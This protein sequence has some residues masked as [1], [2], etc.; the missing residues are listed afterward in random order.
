MRPLVLALLFTLAACWGR[1]AYIVEG[2]VVEVKDDGVV[3]IDHQEIPGFMAAM[4]MP[5][6][7]SDPAA[8]ASLV[9]G[10][11]VVARLMITDDGARLDKIRVTGRVAPPKAVETEGG[12]VRPGQA[13]PKTELPVT[14]GETW[15]VGEGQPTATVLTFLYT[16]CPLPAFCPM[17]VTRLQALQ[18]AL[19]EAGS[20]ARLVA[21]TIDPEGD[22]MDVLTAFAEASGADATR[23]RFARVDRPAL[24]ELAGLAALPMTTGKDDEAEIVHGLRW[25]V[26][27]ADGKLVERYDDNRWP[28]PRVV[29]QL[30]TGGPPAPEGSDGTLTPP[31]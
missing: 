26:L 1:N 14:G 28:M 17:V 7:L 10:H 15:V 5:F 20:D 22:T 3:V 12:P 4:T 19:D 16:T 9:P 24:V 18:A 8:A 23:W 27:D 21:L 13:F 6:T 29:Q 11:T 25:L 2:T 30:T 31:E